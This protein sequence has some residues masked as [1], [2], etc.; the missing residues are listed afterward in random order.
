MATIRTTIGPSAAR[1]FDLARSTKL[2]QLILKLDASP[3]RLRARIYRLHKRWL[4]RGVPALY[5]E[6]R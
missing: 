3:P 1:P 2:D 4:E 5:R 6:V